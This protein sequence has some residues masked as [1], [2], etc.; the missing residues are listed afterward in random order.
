MPIVSS[1]PLNKIIVLVYL[2]F[3]TEVTFI[4]IFITRYVAFFLWQYSKAT[5][6]V[7]LFG[8]L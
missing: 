5:K 2:R 1:C 7:I 3:L 4:V 6:E 8:F